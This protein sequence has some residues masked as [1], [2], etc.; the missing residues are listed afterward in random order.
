M[1]DIDVNNPENFY[2]LTKKQHTTK[3][4]IHTNSSRLGKNW[5]KT[6]KGVIDQVENMNLSKAGNK[7]MFQQ[8]LKSMAKKERISKNNAKAVKGCH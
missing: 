5:N 4:G 2:N 6:W 7:K 1:A 8:I 3:P